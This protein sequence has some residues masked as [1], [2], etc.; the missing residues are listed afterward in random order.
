MHPN[1][2]G[3][4]CYFY[5]FS[6]YRPERITQPIQWHFTEIPI[7]TDH[8]NEHFYFY[9]KKGIIFLVQKPKSGFMLKTQHTYKQ[10]IKFKF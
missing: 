2:Y 5:A 7:E 6:T 8:L 10:I 4:R 1:C 9:Q 3:L